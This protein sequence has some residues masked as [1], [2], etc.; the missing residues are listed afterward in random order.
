MSN[1]YVIAN[2]TIINETNV[3]DWIDCFLTDIQPKMNDLDSYY[4]GRDEL[5]KLRIDKR[6]ADNNIHINLASMIVSDVVAYCFGKPMTY[7]FVK[8]YPEEEYIRDLQYKNDEEMENIAIAKDCSKYGL[9][10]EY[11][12]VN[13]NKEPFFKRLSPLSTFKVVDDTIL[14][15]DV[16]VITYT[17]VKPKNKTAY[18]SGY[19]YTPEYRV[20]FV[21]KSSKVSFGD[22]EENVEYPN[23][24]P[25]VSYKNNDEVLGDYEPAL[26]ALSAYS[27][28]F[29]GSFD[30]VD[31]VS[32]AV[33]LFYNADLNEEDKQDLNKTR[34]IGMQGENCKAEYIYKKLDVNFV[35]W[36]QEALKVE[37]LSICSVPDMSDIT[38]YSK[39]GAAIK[40]K[41]LSLENKRRLKNI[42][43][44]KGLRKR[45]EI[46]SKYSGKPFSITR[47]DVNLQFYSNLP[48]NM[49]LD[50]ELMQLVNA[51]GKSLLSALRQMESVENAEEEY[52]L[53]R[54]EQKSKVLEALEQVRNENQTEKNVDL[55]YDEE[56]F[57]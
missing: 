37:I 21:Y 30:D 38:A 48:T 56:I 36:L 27:K 35:K 40:Y 17:I 15:N 19:V 2:E 10:Y 44:E 28:I 45:L 12:G 49:E 53:I 34:V 25:I 24:L 3:K 4:E 26:E 13:E 54:E 55:E 29:S 52:M 22:K 42:Y 39:S 11:I 23:T 5:N 57:S 7:D 32:N 31:E 14:A 8:E 51:G 33:L 1:K 20:P 6:R 16:C 50:L 46:I 41:V 47:N 43:M 9:A 18:K